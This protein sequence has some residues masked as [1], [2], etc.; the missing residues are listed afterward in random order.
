[1]TLTHEELSFMGD[2]FDFSSYKN[3][4]GATG[5][6][7]VEAE[8]KARKQEDMVLECFYAG[9]YISQPSLRREYRRRYGVEIE[10][11]SCS[12]AFA[13]LTD[14]GKLIKTGVRVMGDRGKMVYTWIKK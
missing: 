7:L 13:N 4:N 11:A 5:A 12:R 14:Q 3:T 6:E 10:K 2:L 9:Q 8:K 1:M